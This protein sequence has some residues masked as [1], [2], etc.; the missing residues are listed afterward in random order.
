M[1]KNITIKLSKTIL[2]RIKL[3]KD[4][5]KGET[6]I[7][8]GDGVSI[9]YF[10]LSSF[11]TEI[12]FCVGNMMFHNQFNLLNCKYYSILEPYYFYPYIKVPR[13]K[14]KFFRN[15]IQK[16]YRNFIK[17][18]EKINFF[19]N[20]SNYPV[21]WNSNIFYLYKGLPEKDFKF[22]QEWNNHNRIYNEDSIYKGSLRGAISL[23]IYM[24]FKKIVLV[25]F[26]YTHEQAMSKHWF[27]KGKGLKKKK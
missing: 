11:A 9:K 20:L 23:S 19:I 5:H 16:E 14:N 22:M 27:E 21:L 1:L 3:L 25:G 8:I 10:D 15:K 6:C 26:D 4:I 7:L 17:A 24:G 13:T 2:N 12:S 18:K